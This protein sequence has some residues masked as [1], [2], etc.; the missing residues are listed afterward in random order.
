MMMTQAVEEQDFLHWWAVVGTDI[1][2]PETGSAELLAVFFMIHETAK[3]NKIHQ[4]GV[5]PP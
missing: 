1:Y 2:P 3:M 5:I 4:T